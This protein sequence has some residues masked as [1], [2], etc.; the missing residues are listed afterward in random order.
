M[1]TNNYSAYVLRML[2]VCTCGIILNSCLNKKI[3]EAH[4]KFIVIHPIQGDSSYIQEYVA[5]IQSIQ[6]VE[7][8]ARAK[9]FVERIYVDEGNTVVKGQ[10]LFTLNSSEYLQ[11]IAK[12]KAQ[13]ATAEA[14]LRQIDVDLKNTKH[15]SDRNIISVTELEL[16]QAKEDAILSKIQEAKASISLA[17]IYLGFTEIRA[18]FSGVVNRIPNKVGS[19]VDEGTLLTTISNNNEMFA[20]FNVSE[21]DYLNHITQN[22]NNKKVNLKLANGEAFLH[23]GV[24]ETIDGEIDQSTGNLS[25]RAKFPNP[26]KLLKHGSSGKV[27]VSNLLTNAILIPQQSTFEVQENLYVYILEEDNTV[28]QRQ[29]KTEMRLGNMY[30]IK[31]GLSVSDKVLF[32]GVQIVK[33]GDKIVP[34]FKEYS[35]LNK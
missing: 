29:I 13:L 6:N 14:E 10:L 8:R 27:L 16:A 25:F 30:V 1:K 11:E 32:E 21:T 33:E 5:D 31:E 19:L 23:T 7:L 17:N 12:A 24:I 26:D 3:G 18:P 15:L 34:E 28:K 4:E 20:Y 22:H 35:L 9:G 2:M